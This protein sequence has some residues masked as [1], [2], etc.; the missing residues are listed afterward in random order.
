MLQIIL[1]WHWLRKGH[2]QFLILTVIDSTRYVT[3]RKNIFGLKISGSFRQAC[4]LC[5]CKW[6][7]EWSTY[8]EK[9]I[10]LS[11]VSDS[12]KGCLQSH[13]VRY[14]VIYDQ[15]WTM[16]IK[17]SYERL[18]EKNEEFS[19]KSNIHKNI[20]TT[21]R[22]TV[23]HSYNTYK[24]WWKVHRH[25][26][27]GFA[28]RMQCHENTGDNE[29]QSGPHCP[30][31]LNLPIHHLLVSFSFLL[32]LNRCDS[33]HADTG[34]W[35]SRTAFLRYRLPTA[36]NFHKQDKSAWLSMGK[37]LQAKVNLSFRLCDRSEQ[38]GHPLNRMASLVPTLWKRTIKTWTQNIRQQTHTKSLTFFLS[39]S[40][41]ILSFQHKFQG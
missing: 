6:V 16:N 33:H 38:F 4:N 17:I 25:F 14:S 34:R 22:S 8:V 13:L 41:Q 24:M 19:F 10:L 36:I 2:R 12:R 26:W 5:N 40:N 32:R 1:R 27:F 9:Y 39:Q 28:W 21:C 31:H 7:N 20:K 35:G 15:K 30:K 3:W 29:L 23:Y 18:R 11:R 37:S